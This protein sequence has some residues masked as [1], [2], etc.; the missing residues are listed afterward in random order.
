MVGFRVPAPCAMGPMHDPHTHT[1]IDV[2]AI[3]IYEH[4]ELIFDGSD[5]TS[6]VVLA[7]AEDVEAFCA[8]VAAGPLESP[9]D[10]PARRNGAR[11]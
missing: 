1:G 11:P 6:Y 3:R 2:A 5:P 10:Y 9:R 7:T 8:R 4:D